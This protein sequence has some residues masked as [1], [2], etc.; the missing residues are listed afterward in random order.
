[1]DKSIRNA[2]LRCTLMLGVLIS[3]YAQAP[4]GTITGTVTDSSGAVVPNARVTVVNKANKT[5]RTLTANGTGLFSAPA[6]PPG[7]YEV[8]AE[9]E[10]FRTTQ[11]DA[12]VVAGSTTTAD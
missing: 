2:V 8:R 5:T 4:D 3:A 6:L 1:M 10:G 7:D 11:R 9:M 12:S